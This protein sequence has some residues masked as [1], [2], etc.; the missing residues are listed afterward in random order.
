[1][2]NVVSNWIRSSRYDI[3]T[4][5]A[6]YISKRY[7]YVIFMCHLSVEKALKAILLDRRKKSPPKTHDLLRLIELSEITVPDNHRPIIAHLNEA[8]VPTRYPEDMSKLV[9]YYNQSA[10]QR[11]L[12]ETK[13]L[14]R[15]LRTLVK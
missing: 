7:V 12:K 6:L 5:E 15:W 3:K 2:N 11:Y 10:A 14:L 13:E 4:A 8:S 1:M 9:R